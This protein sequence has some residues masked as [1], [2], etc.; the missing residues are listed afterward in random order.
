MKPVIVLQPLLAGGFGLGVLVS[1]D[2]FLGLSFV[3]GW[4]QLNVGLQG[5]KGFGIL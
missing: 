1:Y 2:G 4:W 3:F 5:F